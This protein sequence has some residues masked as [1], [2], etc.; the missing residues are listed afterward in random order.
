M[1]LQY[2]KDLLLATKISSITLQEIIHDITENLRDPAMTKLRECV[3]SG[4]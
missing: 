4:K 3:N 1:L 2:K